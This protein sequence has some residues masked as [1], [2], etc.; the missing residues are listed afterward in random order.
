MQIS[1][2]LWC[3][4]WFSQDI[5]GFMPPSGLFDFKNKVCYVFSNIHSILVWLYKLPYL[6]S[7]AF[8]T[9]KDKIRRYL[10]RLK[11]NLHRQLI[12]NALQIVFILFGSKS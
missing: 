1:K 12:L 4:S 10:Q 9:N 7:Q 3:G 8:F 6:N 11:Q 2:Y 5:C